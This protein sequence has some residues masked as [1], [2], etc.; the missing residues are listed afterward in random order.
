[1]D[2]ALSQSLLG[3]GKSQRRIVS[4]QVKFRSVYIPTPMF[5]MRSNFIGPILMPFC[6]SLISRPFA[7][8]FVEASRRSGHGIF[9]DNNPLTYVV[10]GVGQA[11]RANMPLA[12]VRQGGGIL[13]VLPVL[14][15]SHSAIL[16]ICGLTVC[17]IGVFCGSPVFLASSDTAVRR[18]FV[19]CFRDILPVGIIFAM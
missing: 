17:I 7:M 18:V 6:F 13:S 2:Q 14:L 19:A 3:A 12:V 8:D 10:D 15:F 5:L 9:R 1:M 16:W 11:L 4:S